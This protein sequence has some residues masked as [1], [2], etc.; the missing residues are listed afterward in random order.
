MFQPA[1]IAA[2]KIKKIRHAINE[3]AFVEHLFPEEVDVLSSLPLSLNVLPR[4]LD[5]DANERAWC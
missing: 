5:T 1:V 2:I 4:A 3:N